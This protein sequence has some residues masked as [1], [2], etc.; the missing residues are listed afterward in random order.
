MTNHNGTDP[1]KAQ[2][3]TPQQTKRVDKC[4]RAIQRAL[5]RHKCLIVP[6]FIIRGSTITTSILILP[7]PS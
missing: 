5:N 7:R 3:L 1:A 6:Q 4:Q 2:P